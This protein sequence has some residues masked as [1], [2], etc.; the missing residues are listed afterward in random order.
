MGGERD[1]EKSRV[2]PV[3][4]ARTAGL[5]EF[6]V[7][8]NRADMANERGNV[9]ERVDSMFVFGEIGPLGKRAGVGAG[10]P[11]VAGEHVPDAGAWEPARRIALGSIERS[12]ARAGGG[13]SRFEVAMTAGQVYTIEVRPVPRDTHALVTL[14]GPAGELVGCEGRWGRVRLVHTAPASGVSLV[15]AAIGAGGEAF[16]LQVTSWTREEVTRAVEDPLYVM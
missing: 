13:E 14:Y 11:L 5:A 7:L 15:T 16:V 2:R 9:S 10:V 8:R 12:V 3:G 1:T 4:G 6:R